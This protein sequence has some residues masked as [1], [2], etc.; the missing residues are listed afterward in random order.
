M[1]LL[2][3]KQRAE[4][5]FSFQFSFYIHYCVLDRVVVGTSAKRA[6]EGEGYYCAVYETEQRRVQ[7]LKPS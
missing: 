1:I 6:E 5:V 3:E 7:E 4:V 2:C